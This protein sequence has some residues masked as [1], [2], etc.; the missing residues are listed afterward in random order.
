MQTFID[1]LI[2]ESS[3]K[4]PHERGTE[5]YDH[6]AATMHSKLKSEALNKT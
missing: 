2:K 5:E 3:S 6:N 4:Y 1:F